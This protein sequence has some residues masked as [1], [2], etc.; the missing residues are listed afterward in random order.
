MAA[1]GID[2]IVSGLDT[3][4]LINSLMKVEAMPQTLLKSKVSTTQTF[5]TALQ[6]LNS[7]VSSL[8][9]AAK[10]AARP[11]SW[12]AV[13]ATTTAKSVTATATSGAGASSLSFTVDALAAPQTSV[14]GPVS[15]LAQLFADPGDPA[16][17]GTVPSTVTIRT[18]SGATEKLTTVPLGSATDLAGFAAVLNKADAGVTASVVR[19]SETESR[20]QLTSR[21]TGAPAA[22][23][24]LPG[25]VTADDAG[26]TAPVLARGDA[27][28]AAADAA[29]TLWK[30]TT[31]EQRVT[32]TTNTFGQ[33]LTGV[34]L[35][36]S[37]LEAAP[38][39][40]TVAR[41][42][43]ALKKLAS[44]LVGAVGVVLSEVRSRTA[45]STTTSGDGRTVVAG[46]P[47]SGDSATRGVQ[48]AVLTAAS[49]PVDGIS[50]SEVGL[51]LGRD[52]TMTF[53]EARFTAALA[54]DPAKVQRVVAGVAARVQ[55]AATSLSDPV[56]GTLSL[57]IKSQET[58]SRS[59]SQQVT[60]WDR[61][62]ELR[63]ESLQKTYSAL[64]V[65]LSNLQAQSG[66]LAG[67]LNALAATA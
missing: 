27:I 29:I 37:A 3:T 20:L 7:K 65:G 42:D 53:D 21:A 5:I 59:L 17:P 15:T 8:A 2:G 36:V 52:G 38:V 26:A 28:V 49:H 22:F 18:G 43:A 45:T 56:D 55:T 11:A 12:D 35:T 6:G 9:D 67:Q 62:L 63:R 13:T 16:D 31:A 47:L 51:V 46:G 34:S 58:A 60:D 25:T 30:G 50:P 14:S 4:S 41:D 57:K 54:A 64:E 24:L 39:G 19:V 23:D 44:N 1:M 61:R 10:A 66:W 40:V 48:G 33:V 32:S